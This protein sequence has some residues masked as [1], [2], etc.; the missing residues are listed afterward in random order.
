M[1]ETPRMAFSY[2]LTCRRT[3]LT[4]ILN[5]RDAIFDSGVT[6]PHVIGESSRGSRLINIADK[7]LL[8]IQLSVG[9]HLRPTSFPLPNADWPLEVNRHGERDSLRFPPFH[10]D[11]I[12]NGNWNPADPHG[13]IRI[14]ISETVV[15]A[16]SLPAYERVKD[17]VG[18]SFQHAPLRKSSFSPGP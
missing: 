2:N 16:H 7:L 1:D 5:D 4:L 3:P 12:T 11:M 15:H 9:V 6:W 18:F 17:L 8:Q 13:R 10:Q 14:I